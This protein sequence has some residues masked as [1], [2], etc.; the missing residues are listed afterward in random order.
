[1]AENDGHR[2]AL[3]ALAEMERDAIE[4]ARAEI[5]QAR[6]AGSPPRDKAV[7]EPWV[8]S[9]PSL[10]PYRPP[11]AGEL[12]AMQAGAQVLSRLQAMEAA[13][14]RLTIPVTGEGR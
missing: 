9:V 14:W 10:G 13:R 11:D 1:M 6:A 3:R 5:D 4:R 2:R 7:A 12:A 8:L